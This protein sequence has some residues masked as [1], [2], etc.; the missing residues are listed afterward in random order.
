[1]FYTR[2]R[3]DKMFQNK[4][5]T[6]AIPERVY[7]LCKIVE[8]KATS[9]AEV[10][11]RMEPS[12][13]NQKT[14]YYND[15]RTAA[16]EL[17][18]IT[19][20]DNV[21]SLGV[22]SSVL[23]SMDTMRFYINGQ[24]DKFREGQFYK[25]T[26]AYYDMGESI[27]H[28]EQNVANMASIMTL[29]T[30][31]SVD[32]MAMRAWRF[33]AAYLGF[34]YLQDMFVIPNADTFLKDIIKRADFDKN[35]RYSIV[36]FL[37]KIRPYAYIIIDSSKESKTFNFGVSNGLRTLQ[38]AGFIKMEHIMDQEDTWNLYHINELSANEIITNITILK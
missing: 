33:W 27:L 34:G 37:E 17:Q 28:G 11:E 19:I 29:K 13:L 26:K 12:Y 3:G 9:S 31:V 16:E 24:L 22:D 1:M 20:T 14:S 25:V 2:R 5:V 15:Y 18:L 23:K 10:K 6:P 36:S 8:K 7:T 4:M 32:S 21:L 35:K 30:G 38:D